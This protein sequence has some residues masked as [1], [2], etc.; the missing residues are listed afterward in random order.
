[1]KILA[2]SD[3]YPIHPRLKK[4]SRYFG[5]KEATTFLLWNRGDSEIQGNIGEIV[6][7]LPSVLGNKWG[8][9][10]KLIQFRKAVKAHLNLTDYEVVIC[11]HWQQLFLLLS[12]SNKKKYEIIYD[13]CDMPNK[14]WIRYIESKLIKKTNVVVLASRF[15]FTDYTT[16]TKNLIVLE[17]RPWENVNNSEPTFL[18]VYEEK[19][20][21]VKHLTFLGRIRYGDILIRLIKC[22]QKNSEIVLNFYGTGPD[23]QKLIHFVNQNKIKNVFF[24]GEYSE[25]DIPS[26]YQKSDYIWA[27]YDNHLFNVKK[28][29][30]NKFFETLTYQTPGIFAEDTEL[31]ALI[32]MQGIGLI[33]NPYSAESIEH[34]LKKI[35][36]QSVSNEIKENQKNWSEPLYFDNYLGESP[37]LKINEM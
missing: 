16:K 21:S 5:G 37:Y 27:A 11:R 13:V 33:V 14:K 4:V 30:S 26:I 10:L 15:F 9:A 8:K 34:C 7:N 31:G 23:E 24:Y 25:K 19:L 29:I 1:M 18:E 6:F 12:I 28:A 35:K 20:N 17:N 22:V 36:D 32:D 3:S 2:I